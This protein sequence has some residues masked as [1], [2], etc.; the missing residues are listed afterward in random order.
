[1]QR[2]FIVVVLLVI[3]SAALAQSLSG[4][5]VLEVG[6]QR[7]VLLLREAAGQ[8][9]GTLTTPDATYQVLGRA[10]GAEIEGTLSDGVE[11]Y[12]FYGKIAGNQLELTVAELDDTNQPDQS[13]AERFVFTRQASS[14]A[15]PTSPAPSTAPSNPAPNQTAPA[16]TALLGKFSGAGVTLELKASGASLTGSILWQGKTYPVNAQGSGSKVYGRFVVGNQTLIFDAQLSGDVMTLLIA[17]KRYAL[18]RVAKS[19][20]APAVTIPATT[21]TGTVEAKIGVTY[22]AGQR[23]TAPQYGAS[24]VIPTGL[25]GDTVSVPLEKMQSRLT[26]TRLGDSKSIGGFAMPMVGATREDAV[27]LAMQGNLLML[28]GY[29][30]TANRV[31]QIGAVSIVRQTLSNQ[32]GTL[33][34]VQ[35]IALGAGNALSFTVFGAAGTENQLEALALRLAQSAKFTQAPLNAALNAARAKLS[36]AYLLQYKYTGGTGN[37]VGGRESKKRL[38]LCGDSS[39]R[40][41]GNSEAQYYFPGSPNSDGSSPSAYSGNGNADGGRWRLILVGDWFVV[42][43]YSA[44]GGVNPNVLTNLPGTGGKLPYWNGVE[45]SAF[46]RG[47]C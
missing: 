23:V 29:E 1:M 46:G 15:P 42:N 32:Q 18:T 20:T 6:G 4:S 39:Y 19:V 45:L 21:E 13:T 17:G 26:V 5:Y 2:S 31:A 30:I 14:V 40:F 24:F 9:T 41:E 33:S 38:D 47:N 22:K 11:Q 27:A 10:R 43:L 28:F 7:S 44:G 16:S 8:V 35:T 25:T 3:L 34:S 36:G 37:V 12:Y